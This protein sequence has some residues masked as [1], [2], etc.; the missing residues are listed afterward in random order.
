MSQLRSTEDEHLNFSESISRVEQQMHFLTL[1]ISLRGFPIVIYKLI[2]FGKSD[3]IQ[4]ENIKHTAWK[5]PFRYWEYFSIY[6][7]YSL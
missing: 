7:R 4:R 5:I 6:F 3:V 2:L 1:S